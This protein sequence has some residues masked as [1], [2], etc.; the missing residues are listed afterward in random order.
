MIILVGAKAAQFKYVNDFKLVPQ[1]QSL[2]IAILIDIGLGHPFFLAYMGSWA[3]PL[4][5]TDS[6]Q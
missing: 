6:T 3:Q 5:D 2:I 1:I 4:S